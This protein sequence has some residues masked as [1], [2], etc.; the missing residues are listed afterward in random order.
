MLPVKGNIALTLDVDWAP[1]WMIDA[2]AEI[3]IRNRVKATWFMTHLSPAVSRLRQNNDL[4]ELGVHPNCLPGSTQ[5]NTEDEILSNMKTLFPEAISMRTHGLYQTTNFLMKAACEHGICI[6]LSLFIPEGQNLKPHRLYFTEG[7]IWRI[8]YNWEDD[9]EILNPTPAWSFSDEK[10]QASGLQIYNFHPVHIMLNT[11]NYEYYL[12]VKSSIPK[13]SGLHD[14]T[15]GR[16]LD[17][18][19]PRHFFKQ[20]VEKLS[21]QGVWIKELIQEV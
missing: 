18:E 9:F 8:P 4:F 20:F 11:T 6:D 3:L 7:S 21:G 10:Y 15:N 5:G 13:S 1:D 17:S 19:G 14:V 16:E 12:T 2:V